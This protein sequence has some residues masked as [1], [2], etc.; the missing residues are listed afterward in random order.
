VS[1]SVRI[2]HV[3][4]SLEVGGAEA[5]V[6]ALCRLQ[7]QAG[8]AVEVHCLYTGGPFK[9]ILEREGIPVWVHGPAKAP[10]LM[11]R[12]YRAFRR[13]KPDVVHC[14]NAAATVYAA[15]PARLAGARAVVSTRHGMAG[16]K[17]H[18]RPEA[19]F[20]ITAA[21]FCDQ[22]VA[23]CE[24]G[25]ENMMKNTG[26]VGRK[27]MTIRNGAYPPPAGEER[28]P[29]RTGFTLITVGRLAPA[30]NYATLLRSVAAARA[31]VP[32]LAL[33]VVG[34]GPEAGSLKA[35]AH[36]LGI[37][38]AVE[39]HGERRDVGTWLRQAD[40]FVLSSI[41]EGLPIAILEAM[42]TGLPAIVTDVGGMPEVIELSRAGTVVPPA[43]VAALAAAI[44]DLANRRGELPDLGRRAVR[45]YEELFTPVRMANDYQ[46]LYEASL[47]RRKAA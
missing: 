33:S 19:K 30:K 6:V 5:V 40:V 4:D 18:A 21:L 39:F 23:V 10:A 47:R 36:D 2:A 12:L 8:N 43:D 13:S 44:V 38:D 20:W 32:D 37:D 42:A 3:L 16:L 15:G 24:R 46:Q 34:D 7:S 41:S 9:D 26:V 1:D 31:C 29:S 28:A 27:V 45:C 11:W 22:V 35:L 17:P 25:R 14:H